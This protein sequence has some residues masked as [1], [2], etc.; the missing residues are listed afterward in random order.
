M[1]AEKVVFYVVK[2][3]I[4]SRATWTHKIGRNDILKTR[5]WC[6]RYDMIRCVDIEPLCRYWRCIEGDASL[7]KSAI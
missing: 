2:G 6:G 1:F 3:Q 4:Y 7:V 5:Y